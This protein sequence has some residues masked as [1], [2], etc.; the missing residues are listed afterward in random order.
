[1]INGLN[2]RLGFSHR[3]WQA[4]GTLN[5]ASRTIVSISRG[6]GAEKATPPL[7]IIFYGEGANNPHKVALKNR[8]A[9]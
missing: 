7:P 6:W 9:V 1:M 8:N 5:P 2:A 4:P 3:F